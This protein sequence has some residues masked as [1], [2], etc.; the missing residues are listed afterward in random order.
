MGRDLSGN[1]GADMPSAI[2]SLRAVRKGKFS[3]WQ[4]P[5]SLRSGRTSLVLARSTR[6]APEYPEPRIGSQ[7]S[8]QMGCLLIF[9]PTG[10]RHHLRLVGWIEC[11]SSARRK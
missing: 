8:R 9:Q 7:A 3:R 5:G 4:S 6:H 10:S 1:M 11:G 2:G